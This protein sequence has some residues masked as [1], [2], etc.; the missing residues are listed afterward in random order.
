M[1]AL[2][3][4]AAADVHRVRRFDAVVLGSA[5]PGLVAAIRI[6]QRGKRVLVIEE[7]A[8]ARTHPGLREPFVL[9]DAAPSGVLGACLRAL[10]TPLIEQRRLASDDH[11]LQLVTSNARLDWSDAR[12]AAAELVSW[13]LAK[14]DDALPLLRSLTAGAQ[15]AR[16]AWL[17]ADAPS[18]RRAA[19]LGRDVPDPEDLEA[20]LARAGEALR[21]ADPPLRTLLRDLG[22][23]LCDLSSDPPPASML[24]LQGGVLGG[25]IV[26][27]PGLRELLWRRLATLF[28]ERRS[29]HGSFQLVSASQLAAVEAPGIQEIW[30]GRVLLLNAPREAL[31]AAHAGTPP[32]LL[33]ANPAPR[34]RVSLH[35]RVPAALL[36][37]AMAKRVLVLGEEWPLRIARHAPRRAGEPADL[38][39]STLAPRT[40]DPEVVCTRLE[41]ALREL[42]PFCGESLERRPAS[43]AR[44]D[45]DDLLPERASTETLPSAQRVSGRP[46]VLVLDRDAA[47]AHG[48]EGE[49]LLGLRA[50]DDALAEIA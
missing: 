20:A 40:A 6:A 8:A 17:G 27:N 42:A 30:A 38:I 14:P 36:P 37:E 19:E 10:A 18:A 31:A 25:A 50:G 26:A 43:G 23:A 33:R 41:R 11:T 5:L 35:A 3:R 32:P 29:I 45:R 46:P 49:L 13:G 15:A 34:R 21:G 28:G 48:Y 12:M 22:R 39:A 24:R 9:W 7:E 16:D 1:A 47:V 2:P 4:I 44:W